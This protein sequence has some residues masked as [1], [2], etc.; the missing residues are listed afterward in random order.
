MSNPE[1]SEMSAS[2]DSEMSP[3]EDSNFSTNGSAKVMC[4]CSLP[5]EMRVSHTPG[6]PFR[7]FYNC[8]KRFTQCEFLQWVD[9]PDLTGDRHVDELNLIRN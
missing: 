2:D 9:E 8:Q 3:S 4:F 1:D 7:L 6:N 5:A